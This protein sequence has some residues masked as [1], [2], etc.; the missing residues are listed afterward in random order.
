VVALSATYFAWVTRGPAQSTQTA[1]QRSA[2][3][4]AQTADQHRAATSAQTA[5]QHGAV[6]G[7]P[8]T[9]AS[10]VAKSAPT[11]E[12]PPS[13]S[14][15]VPGSEQASKVAAGGVPE[16][17]AHEPQLAESASN[18]PA[19]KVTNTEKSGDSPATT[20]RVVE[21]PRGREGAG[22]RPRQTPR[23]ARPSA[24]TETA[25][26]RS[27]TVLPSTTGPTS[28]SRQ[29]DADAVATERLI[30]QDLA[31]F[32][33]GSGTNISRSIGADS[34]EVQRDRDAIE[35]RRL[36]DRDLGAFRDRSAR[37]A[38]DQAFPDIN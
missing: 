36:V 38:P 14:G 15:A 13:P 25:S 5:D 34:R 19:P 11:A 17:P 1:D 10:N 29:N 32:S 9:P 26:A 7:T 23:R 4:S 8:V 16:R 27:E 37:S 33:R 21:G 24:R 2:A 6:L 12:P 18:A 3:M 22:S 20:S 28:T 35:T 31:R 30:A